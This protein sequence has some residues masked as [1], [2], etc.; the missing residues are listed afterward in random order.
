MAVSALFQ[1]S[2]S[3]NPS[4]VYLSLHKKGAADNLRYNSYAKMNPKTGL[5]QLTF[6]FSKSMEHL[7]GEY[8][9]ELHASDYRAIKQEVWDLGTIS[10]WFK[11]G[12]DEGNN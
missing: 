11:Q 12:L 5:Y 6:D 7:N 9:L 2:E 10:V 3:Q 8:N 1:E 4:Q